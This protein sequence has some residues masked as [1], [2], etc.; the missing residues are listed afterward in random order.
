[1]KKLL[2]G[3]IIMMTSLSVFAG[4][5]GNSGGAA[6]IAC[7]QTGGYKFFCERAVGYNHTDERALAVCA[8]VPNAPDN[9][10]YE[11]I[12]GTLNKTFSR[13]ELN[14]CMKKKSFKRIDCITNSGAPFIA[15]DYNLNSGEAALRACE[16][17]G[18]FESFCKRTVGSNHSDK[19]ALKVCAS[20]GNAPDTLKYACIK[21]TLNKVFNS[22][23]L[24]D[25]MEKKGF[26]RIDCISNSGEVVLSNICS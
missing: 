5:C 13:V 6:I 12:K 21:G 8:S 15:E 3:A 19:A 22:F 20:V 11:C 9:L 16:Q 23:E 18:G 14:H 2:I 24:N 26:N 4:S 1:M 25:C 10:K 7:E 17:T